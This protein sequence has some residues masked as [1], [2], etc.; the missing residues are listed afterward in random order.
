[1]CDTPKNLDHKG[2]D[3]AM[4]D[5]SMDCIHDLQKNLPIIFTRQ[6]ISKK[7]GNMISPRT[8]ANL[9]SRKEG[10]AVKVSIGG[11]VGYERESFLQWLGER[12]KFD[13]QG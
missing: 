1:M 10:P 5:M 11:R 7:L 6:V 13:E 9:D 2:T 8:L 12:I 4:Q 3:A